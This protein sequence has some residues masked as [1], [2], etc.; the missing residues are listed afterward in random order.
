[1]R[2]FAEAVRRP[3]ARRI[4]RCG[5][6]CGLAVCGPALLGAGLVEAASSPE[7]GQSGE[8]HVYSCRTPNGEAA[9]VDGWTGSATGAFV[10]A[11]DK[12]GKGGALTAA[13]GDGVEHES[14]TDVATW[15]FGAPVGETL[16]GATVWRA[17]D[18]D[19][20]TAANATYEFWLAAPEETNSFDEC[21]YVVCKMGEGESEEPLAT[22]NRVEVPANDLGSDLFVNAACY[23]TLG[24][25]CK[26]GEH[27][28]DGYAAVVYLYAADLVLAQTS[29]P[30][31]SNVEG[32][33]ADAS[34]LAGTADLAFHAS[35]SGSGV[36][37]AVFAVDGAEVGRTVLD[38]SSRC[39]DVGQTTDGLPA[40]LY[41][42][43]CAESLNADLP[44]DTTQLS[45]GT[46]HLVVSVTNAAGDST[47]ALDRKVEV[48]NHPAPPIAEEP[49]PKEAAPE[50][51]ALMAP[52]PGQGPAG[53]GTHEQQSPTPP[54]LNAQAPVVYAAPPTLVVHWAAGARAARVGT[55][56]NGRIVDGRL[57]EASGTP[58]GRAT[59][60]VLS[61]P[62]FQG[63]HTRVLTTVRTGSGGSFRVRL[64]TS[65]PSS[66]LTFAYSAGPNQAAPSVT[67]QLT[68][69]VAAHVS[70]AVAPRVS[71][72][73]GTIVFKGALSG[74]PLPP[75]GKQV[76]LEARTLN[77]PWREF[78]VLSTAAR[79]RFH[80]SYR[81]RLAGPI[82]YR[83]RAVCLHEADYPYATGSSPPV[84]VHER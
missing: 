19:G 80:A 78:Q 1:M 12:C 42:Q 69:A 66:R 51:P 14:N 45:D 32:E 57:S 3:A 23:G 41:L 52:S 67:A 13:L 58:I 72:V 53:D 8:Y 9:P 2:G 6:A 43:P 40:F 83:F 39:H 46:H 44:F 4:A 21:V 26:K 60:Q 25:P 81:F 56:G 18:A 54:A 37:Q 64:P 11:E 38:S 76:I 65:L 47:V 55:R 63:A 74:G 79:G 48:A 15:A 77:G 75:G 82:D 84:L 20:G 22:G 17:G 16:K 49:A 30:T 29:Q 73:G 10:S 59:V 62:A 28:P 68:L 36:Y 27:D 5:L 31:V 7:V 24:R 61:T 50:T 33:L 34:T 35:D 70:L 71:H